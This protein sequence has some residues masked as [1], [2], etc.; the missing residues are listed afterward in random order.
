MKPQEEGIYQPKLG[1]LNGWLHGCMCTTG[2]VGPELE[3]NL[4][5]LG[6]IREALRGPQPSIFAA[7]KPQMGRVAG[8][9]F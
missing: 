8:D 5:S 7:G 9:L 3:S 1:W 6:M 4:G 2:L